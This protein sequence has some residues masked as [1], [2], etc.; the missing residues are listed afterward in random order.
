MMAGMEAT[1]YTSDVNVLA[2]ALNIERF[3]GDMAMKLVNAVPTTGDLRSIAAPAPPN[4][5]T[6]PNPEGTGTL[7]NIYV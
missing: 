7:V 5:I 3:M 1:K 6:A 2:K 4:P